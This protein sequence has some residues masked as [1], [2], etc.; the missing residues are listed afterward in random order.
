MLLPFLTPSRLAH[1]DRVVATLLPLA[2][3]YG[4]DLIQAEQA[5]LFHDCLK[6]S[7]PE[8]LK[9][10]GIS[11]SD[12]ALQLYADFPAVWHALV[13]PSVLPQ[14]LHGDIHPAVLEA[15]MYHTTGHARMT[16]LTALL[17]VSDYIEPGRLFE[18]C[19]F[20]RSFV[21]TD[22]NR[23]V[24]VTAGATLFYLKQRHMRIHPLSDECFEFYRPFLN[25][26]DEE[27]FT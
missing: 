2:A 7:T 23:A 11:I 27:M 17:Y 13:A 15:I 18:P 24:G 1:T 9:S 20:I 6:A 8:T 25:S 4:V 10:L 16:P 22:L 14:L 26:G 5:A 3:H 19:A 21:Y 12:A